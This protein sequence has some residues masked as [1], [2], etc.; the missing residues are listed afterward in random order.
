M[1]ATFVDEEKVVDEIAEL[2]LQGEQSR[3]NHH[4]SSKVVEAL[5]KV[6]CWYPISSLMKVE[7][8]G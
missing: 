7:S 8:S 4:G 3:L 5:E 1:L 2:R 6:S